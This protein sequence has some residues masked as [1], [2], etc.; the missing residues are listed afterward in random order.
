MAAVVAGDRAGV[1]QHPLFHADHVD[2]GKLQPLGGVQGHQRHRVAL[3]LRFLVLVL[4]AGRQGDVLQEAGQ[5]R[6][7]GPLARSRPG[8]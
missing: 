7:V 2:L 6:L 1:R 5:R 8:R 4:V 3:E